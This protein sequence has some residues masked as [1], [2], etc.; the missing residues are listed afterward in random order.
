MPNGHDAGRGYRP[1]CDECGERLWDFPI[2][3]HRARLVAQSHANA[4]EHVVRVE[5][6]DSYQLVD[7]IRPVP[8]DP[9]VEDD[10]DA[11]AECWCDAC[12][13]RRAAG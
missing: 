2:T 12:A 6:W 1:Y 11:H 5:P 4:T 9:P 8:L 3:L 10:G 13:E 7:L